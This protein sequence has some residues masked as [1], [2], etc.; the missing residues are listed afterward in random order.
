MNAFSSFPPVVDVETVANFRQNRTAITLID[1]RTPA[2]F[3]TAHISGSYN[4]PLDVLPHHAAELRAALHVPAILVCR[5]GTRARQAQQALRGADVPHVHV[6][7]GGITAWEAA[8]K[9]LMR[10]TPRWS[11]ER[12]VRGVAGTLVLF[13]MIGGRVWQPLRGVALLIGA[14]LTFSAVTDSCFMGALL[15]TLPYNQ[16]TPYNVRNV[17]LQLA[18]HS[19]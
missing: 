1:V 16:H 10:G 12:Q 8:G 13:G 7:D 4:V 6:L 3:E 18:D 5:S 17:L 11:L 9:T 2:E 19:L 15:S 14:G